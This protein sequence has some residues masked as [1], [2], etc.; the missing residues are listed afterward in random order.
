MAAVTACMLSVRAQQPPN[1]VSQAAAAKRM[2]FVAGPKDHGADDPRRTIL[3]NA[4]P[5]D[6]ATSAL[7]WAVQRQGGGRGFV[8]AGVDLHKNLL[9]N[10]NR[11]LLVN[12]ILWVAYV[13]VPEGGV[14]CELADEAAK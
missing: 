1:A 7:S 3:L 10:S 14:Q 8:M 9:I 4:K 6:G 11:R 5:K 13:E 2:I 12:G